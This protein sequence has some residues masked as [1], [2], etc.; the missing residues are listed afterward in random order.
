A[1]IFD[2]ATGASTAAASMPEPRANHT[3][4]TLP[5]NGQVII[6]GGTNGKGAL[7]S[8][9]LYTPWQ[10]KF[11]ETGSM[12]YARTGA[13]ATLLQRDGALLVAGGRNTSGYLAGSEVFGFATIETDKRDYH[14]GDVATMIGAGWKPG[15]QV[16][17]EV[18]AFPLDEHRVEF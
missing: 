13:A 9:D 16:Q 10:G 7:A 2:P 5:K 17:V 8:T 14:P 4:Y 18:V 6:V 15:E 1:E 11:T 12:G 3:A